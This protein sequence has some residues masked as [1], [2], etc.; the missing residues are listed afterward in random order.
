MNY[1]ENGIE[2]SEFMRNGK[3]F[4]RRLV[5]NGTHHLSKSSL[6]SRW[7]GIKRRCNN[8]NFKKYEW[9]G[10]KGIKV[11][12]EWDDSFENF[13]KWALPSWKE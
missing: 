6:Y 13:M 3:I 9:Y 7:K 11:C 12:E 1:F 8:P 10:G 5:R 2:Y 4:K